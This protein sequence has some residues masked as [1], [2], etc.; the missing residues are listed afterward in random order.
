MSEHPHTL[1]R[2]Q[3]LRIVGK[4]GMGTVYLAR[5]ER[6]GRSVALKVLNAEDLAS[7]EHRAKFL[8]EARAA[9]AIRHPNVAT[10]FEVGET[11]DG[12]PFIVME[13]C[14]GET[15]AQRIRRA[16]LE[17][18]EFLHIA[19]QIASALAAA[20]GNG[21]VHRDMKSANIIVE[22]SG[23]V[24]ILD[25]GLARLLPRESPLGAETQDS[26]TGRFFG[27]LHYLS[28]EQARGLPGDARS[29]LFSAGVVFYE[30]ASGSLPFN[31][32]A[33]LQVLERIRDAEPERFT[34]R[35][36]KFPPQASQIIGRLLQKDP[37]DRHQ[38]A[39]ELE[40]DL[41]AI[42]IPAGSRSSRG[43]RSLGLTRRGP[44]RARIAML[45]AAIV[46]IAFGV[47]LSRQPAAGARVGQVNLRHGPIRSLAVLPLTNIAH[48]ARDDFLSVGVA[49]ALITKLQQIPDLQIRP[50]SSVLQ[51]R[52]A[53]VDA[54]TAGETLQVD[55]VLEGHFLAAGDL[56][57]INL[58]LTDARSG[59]SVWAQSIDG[60]RE[61]L[62]RLIDDVS[63]RT[64]AGISERIGTTLSPRQ[65][66]SEPRSSNVAAYEQYVKARALTGSLVEGDYEAQIAALRRAIELDPN[67]AAAHADLAI[68]LSLGQSRSLTAD[69]DALK[70]AEA[71]ARQAVRLDPYLPVAHVALSRAFTRQ[72]GRFPESVR[73]GLAAL[74]LNPNQPDALFA[75][76][77]YLVAAGEIQKAECLMERLLKV[78]PSSNDAKARGYMYINSIDPGAALRAAEYALETKTELA[79][80]DIRSLAYLMLGNIAEAEV[81]AKKAYQSSPNHYAG[82]SLRAM[83]AAARGDRTAAEQAIRTF[84]VDAERTHWAALRVALVY[85]RLGDREK[86]LRWIERAAEL[87]NHTWFALVKHPWLASLQ[88]EPRFQ[89]VITAIKRDLDDVSDDVAGVYPLVCK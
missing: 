20:H 47:Y 22:P 78:D 70:K 26:A 18:A 53:K 43:T 28:P 82:K 89:A 42:E 45:F 44:R 1:A 81:E 38:T 88:S 39:Q 84:E 64:L 14:E 56:V 5:D 48:S 54:K 87:G 57:R 8:R 31:A 75:V 29:D 13:Y 9:A 37:D 85:A 72:P 60:K 73:E 74:R 51:Y 66:F 3:I 40:E 11:Q 36:P 41:A 79:G 25:F 15:L 67:F 33:P 34:P 58:Q 68:A 76:T 23:T 35:D 71:S 10:I 63:T 83:I 46:A 77:S 50:T 2:F 69:P 86:A 61:D 17:T 16:P 4:G 59:Y 30:M 7:D 49:D 32:P 62:L 55:G 65:R 21:V 27:T 80:Y 19:R 6:L 24:K 12:Q 52:T